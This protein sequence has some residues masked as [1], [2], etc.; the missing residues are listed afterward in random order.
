[1]PIMVY[2]CSKC[3]DNTEII[4]KFDNKPEYL[5]CDKCK[6][7]MYYVL[8]PGGVRFYGDG[9]YKPTKRDRDGD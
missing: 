6:S 5:K 3:G 4:D 2:E 9:Y 8:A 7:K 1:M